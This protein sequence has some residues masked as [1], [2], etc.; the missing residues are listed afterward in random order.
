MSG[1]QCGVD[2][3]LNSARVFVRDLKE[4]A[5]F[6]GETLGFS[7]SA[8]GIE[9]GAC[10]YETGGMQLVVEAV[11]PDAPQDEQALVGRYTGLCFA[12]DDIKTVHRQL[13]SLGVR[14]CSEPEQQGWGGWLDTFLDPANNE[15]Q[16]VQL[17][18]Y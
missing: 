8:G 11:G 15:M 7:Q 10:I 16:L 12:V 6:Y 14:F 9:H 3:I 18:P 2:M 17:A 4:A 13:H 1:I 5:R